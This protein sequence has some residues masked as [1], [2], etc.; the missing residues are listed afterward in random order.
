MIIKIEKGSEAEKLLKPLLQE[1]QRR[2]DEFRQ[3]LQ[4]GKFNEY[5]KKNGFSQPNH[6][7]KP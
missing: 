4:D 5:A 1:K 3:A 6:L 7:P 2:Q